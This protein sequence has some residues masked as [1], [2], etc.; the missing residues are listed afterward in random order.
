MLAHLLG[1]NPYNIL[2]NTVKPDLQKGFSRLLQS[3]SLLVVGNGKMKECVLLTRNTFINALALSILG[4]SMEPTNN[5]GDEN[6]KLL[7]DNDCWDKI[8][9]SWILYV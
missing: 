4:F 6:Q 5:K 8:A 9:Q 1:N 3:S 2:E 7:V